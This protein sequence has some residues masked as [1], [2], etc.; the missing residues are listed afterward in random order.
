MTKTVRY[1]QGMATGMDLGFGGE[2]IVHKNSVCDDFSSNVSCTSNISGFV[3]LKPKNFEAVFQNDIL[4]GAKT[5]CDL[6]R[7]SHNV[8]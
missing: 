2:A 7:I 8:C 6:N 3:K 4:E 5:I 1:V